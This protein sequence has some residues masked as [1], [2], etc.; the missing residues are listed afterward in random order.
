MKYLIN[1]IAILAMVFLVFGAIKFKDTDPYYRLKAKVRNVTRYLEDFMKAKK[2]NL[3]QTMDPERKTPL[4]FIDK[5]TELELFLPDIF[6]RF[7]PKDWESFWEVIY[8]PVEKKE[9]RFKVKKH[10]TK[11]E[12]TK[13]FKSKYGG[14][15][16]I[17][18]SGHWS[19]F[20]QIV[21]DE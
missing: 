21:L 16:L 15:F 9:G 5:E 14:A 4:T 20:W 2:H 7:K 8:D 12:L 1:I 11:K 6:E 10:R 19:Y 17:F 13:Y 18:D 3:S